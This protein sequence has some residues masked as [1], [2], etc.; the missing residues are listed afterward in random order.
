MTKKTLKFTISIV[1]ISVLALIYIYKCQKPLVSVILPTY[2]RASFLPKAIDSILAQTYKN[3]ELIIINDGSTD[4][5]S[6]ILNQYAKKDKRIRVLDNITNKQITY[7]RNRGLNEAQGKYIA[8]IDDDDIAEKNKIEEQVSFMEKHPD[9]TIL[10]TDISL[11]NGRGRVYLWPVEYTPD[12]A[13]IVFLIGR[14]PII[15]ATSMWRKDFFDKNNIRFNS[16]L[17]FSE[18]LVIY[19]ATLKNGGKIMTLAKTLYRYRSHRDNPPSYYQK[20]P[21]LQYAFYTD[22]WQKFYPDTQ[23]PQNQCQRLDY[24][25]K[26]NQYFNQKLVESMYK[27]HC[28]TGTFLPTGYAWFIP[29]EDEKEAVVVSKNGHVFYS[30]KM[31]KFGTLIKGN[32]QFS[33]IL[34]DGD[35]EIIRYIVK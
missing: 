30:Y 18:D 8:W 32:N 26:N 22:R 25:R 24:I 29:F 5:T 2:N 19:D 33:D 35:D 1:F 31:K 10:G 6:Q 28:K 13:E 21:R 17:P 9:I 15:L 20:I 23:Y 7:S 16:D 27:Q 4:N 34:W 3:I 12:E 14:L 11:I